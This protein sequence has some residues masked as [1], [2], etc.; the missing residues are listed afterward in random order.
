MFVL[1]NTVDELDP[2]FH[3]YLMFCPVITFD[4]ISITEFAQA[5]AGPTGTGPDTGGGA[6]LTNTV[7]LPDVVPP[8]GQEAFPIAVTV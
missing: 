1:N 2:V 3:E 8:V 7:A 6:V 5:S 4:V